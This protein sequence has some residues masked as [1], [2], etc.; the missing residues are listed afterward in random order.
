MGQS[1][2][3]FV[4]PVGQEKYYVVFLIYSQEKHLHFQEKSQ[5]ESGKN[6]GQDVYEPYL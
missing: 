1:F 5:G 6:I 2:A 4:S 3:S